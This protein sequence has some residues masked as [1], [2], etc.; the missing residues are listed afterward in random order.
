MCQGFLYTYRTRNWVNNRQAFCIHTD[1]YTYIYTTHRTRNWVNNRQSHKNI[2]DVIIA[3]IITRI[4]THTHTHDSL[5]IATHD[6]NR[7]GIPQPFYYSRV[8]PLDRG[9]GTCGR[10]AVSNQINRS[11][12]FY[13]NRGAGTCP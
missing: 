2:Q 9:A 13:L 1:A 3:H 7:V 11:R 12:S 10:V 5:S 8:M 6:T 4:H